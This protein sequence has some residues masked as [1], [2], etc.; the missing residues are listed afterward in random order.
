MIN[1]CL[2]HSTERVSYK[3]S[4]PFS[5][6]LRK[7]KRREFKLDRIIPIF[8]SLSKNLGKIYKS[9]CEE[10]SVI[11]SSILIEISLLPNPAMQKVADSLGMDITT[12]SR[13]IA[14]L[15]K[16]KLV[17]RTPYKEDRR[18]YILSLT[19]EGQ[20]LIGKIDTEIFKKMEQALLSMN[21]FER[22]MVL[23]SIQIFDEKLKDG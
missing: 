23:K 18:R 7:V 22:D 1:L 8:H 12:F 14:T 6:I 19:A 17:I 3:T 21:E 5:G 16:K 9:S 15:E 13:Q 2:Y 10:I 11:Q 20:E 4:A